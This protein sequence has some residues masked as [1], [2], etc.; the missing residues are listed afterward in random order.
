MRVVR[1][2]EPERFQPVGYWASQGLQTEDEVRW[3]MLWQAATS[4]N[5]VA[6]Q[7]RLH[8][9]G[10]DYCGDVLDCFKHVQYVMKPGRPM[11]VA[12]CPSAADLVD[13]QHHNVAPEIA[14]RISAHVQ[15][16]EN[17]ARELKWM[18]KADRNSTRVL[19][20][21]PRAKLISLLAVAAVLVIAAA[22][23]MTVKKRNTYTP[24]EDTV[25][26]AK[27]RDLARLPLLDR[28]D[29]VSAAPPSHWQSLDK[30]MS[31]LEL[32]DTRRAVGLAARMI[33]NKDEPAAEYVLGRALYRE[34]MV[35]AAKDALVKAEQMSPMSAF[36]CWTALQMGLIL[37]EKDLVL[38]ECNH[39]EKSPVYGEQVA[40]I[41][42]E[43]KKRG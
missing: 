2:S 27:Y 23:S 36:R 38:R 14:E 32:G 22:A 8:A 40:K 6:R 26:S 37:G 25:Y 21:T 7:V 42:E 17:C 34:R 1:C 31:A 35:S 20:M 41:L 33:N 16:C 28:S 24:I 11:T 10:C 18:E 12:I 5:D 9:E 19:F 13:F 39:L 3:E 30:A 29:L 43:V 15:K 4:E